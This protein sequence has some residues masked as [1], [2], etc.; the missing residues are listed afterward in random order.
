MHASL[1]RGGWRVAGG[2]AG[3]R[4]RTPLWLLATGYWLLA[5]SAL[6]Q[7]MAPAREAELRRHFPR[8]DD[9]AIQ[10]V[11]DDPGLLLY[12]DHE[13]EPAY[14]QWDG[15]LPGL[16]AVS[17]NISADPREPFGNGNREFP[18]GTPAGLHQARH[19][20]FRFLRL[21]LRAGRRLPVA[22]FRRLRRG[23]HVPAYEWVFP[24]GTVVGEVLIQEGPDGR[25][26]AFELRT[27]TRERGE[28]A[29]DAFRPF[30]TPESLAAAIKRQ[31]DYSA[32]PTLR[33]AVARLLSPGGR[34]TAGELVA[35]HP[36]PSFRQTALVEE[37]PPLPP[38][39]VARLLTGT[40]FRSALGTSWRDAGQHT[41]AAPTTRE[42]F[43]VVPAGYAAGFVEVDRQ[44]CMRCHESTLAHVRE[45]EP[46]RDWY[47]RIRGSDGIFSFHPFDSASISH[48]GRGL[49]VRLNPRL[50]EAG[51]V[52]PYDAGRHPASL[53]HEL[54]RP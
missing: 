52:E 8:V 32:D 17:Y 18:W 34:A 44:S 45:F 47:G 35:R 14:Q 6:G 37:L 16:H 48:N 5:T 2:R 46:R 40:P 23:D 42:P 13:I 29:V 54:E 3:L 22:V 20:V 28:W 41:A 25:G 9:P 38:R 50:V 31:P 19:S 21:P 12:T 36:R 7:L 49:P 39:L 24:V 30:P 27:R 15:A 4:R 43:H 26:Y 33:V 1:A 53:Y 10:A 51:I 11:L